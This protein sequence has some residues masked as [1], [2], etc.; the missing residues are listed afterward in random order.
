[1]NAS[2]GESPADVSVRTTFVDRNHEYI[3]SM[4]TFADQKA[5]FFF[6]GATA[7]LAFLHKNDLSARWLRSPADWRF[8]DAAAAIA[9]IALAIGAILALWVV[10]PRSPGSRRGFIFWEAIA[11]FGSGRDYS[12]GLTSFSPAT[13]CQMKA[14]H[15]FDLATVCR[16]KYR[17]LRLAVRVCGVGLLAALVVFLFLA[18]PTIASIPS[19]SSNIPTRLVPASPLGK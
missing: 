3:R 2:T 16:E 17:A 6:A 4:I 1:M 13:L 15:C 9:M 11:E 14:E 7:L 12:D 5:S 8:L 18:R 19:P 10:I